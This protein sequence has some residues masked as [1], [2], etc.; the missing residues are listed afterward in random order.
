MLLNRSHVL[1]RSSSGQTALLPRIRSAKE[2]KLPNELFVASFTPK[3]KPT[4]AARKALD[5]K[6]NPLHLRSTKR[7]LALR[8]DMLWVHVAVNALPFDATRRRA[9]RHWIEAAL[10]EAFRNA[11]FDKNSILWGGKRVEMMKRQNRP[12]RIT[13]QASVTGTL[14]ITA[15]K[16]LLCAERGKLQEH[17]RFIVERLRGLGRE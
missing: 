10:S 16:E 13:S 1:M 11:N 4:F 6:L 3:H 8:R 7:F 5:D 17:I 12:Q 2:L 14:S 9:C 15:K